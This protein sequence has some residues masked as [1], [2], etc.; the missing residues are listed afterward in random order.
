M[1]EAVLNRLSLKKIKNKIQI[2]F[3]LKI[4]PGKSAGNCARNRFGILA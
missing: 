4:K 2:V 3:A 1:V